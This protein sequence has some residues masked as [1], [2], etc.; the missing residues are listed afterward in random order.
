MMRRMTLRRKSPAPCSKR[1]RNRAAAGWLG[2]LA[3]AARMIP[4]ANRR[5][6]RRAAESA[7]C[8]TTRSPKWQW[9]VWQRWWRRSSRSRTASSRRP[10]PPT[11]LSRRRQERGICFAIRRISTVV[12]WSAQNRRERWVRPTQSFNSR[13]L[14]TTWSKLDM[15]SIKNSSI[16]VGRLSYERSGHREYQRQTA[17]RRCPVAAS[18][19]REWRNLVLRLHLFHKRDPL[20]RP[21]PQ[22]ALSAFFF[23]VRNTCHN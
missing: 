3:S 12:S 5:V 17:T 2:S 13:R 9:L 16:D 6:N 22:R 19:I 18:G 7:G 23:L 10:H 21:E 14:L 20:R 1:T 8:S 15:L 4:L 11:P